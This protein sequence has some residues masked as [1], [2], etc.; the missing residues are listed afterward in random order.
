M[1]DQP[2]QT[3]DC[4]GYDVTIWET[5]GDKVFTY[6]QIG[7]VLNEIAN[8]FAFQLEE[9]EET[10]R[11]HFQIRL[12]AIKKTRWRPLTKLFINALDVKGIKGHI[13]IK[14]TSAGIHSKR[15]F[16]YVLK[17]DTRIA[18]PW[19][20]QDFTEDEAKWIPTKY[21]N[22]NPENLKPFQKSLIEM[23]KIYDD[24]V[25]DVI[26][27]PLG[28]VGK[29]FIK[30]FMY[31]FEDSHILPSIDDYKL[32]N[33]DANNAVANR[34]KKYGPMSDK[35]NIKSFVLDLPRGMEI[36]AMRS[37]CQAIETIKDG[38]LVDWRNKSNT[39]LIDE[40]RIFIFTNDIVHLNYTK[41]RLKTWRIDNKA[42]LIPYTFPKEDKP[43]NLVDYTVQPLFKEKEKEKKIIKLV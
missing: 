24:R 36:G 8:K 35:R 3:V 10:K 14:P 26:Y 40:P 19:T 30:K 31:L 20:E 25:I 34:I 21:R 39:L 23:S 42:C 41:D 33:Q 17:A 5:M 32:V 22:F 29:G 4:K 43:Y 12:N 6:S 11:R 18:G 7:K 28:N 9:G 38:W 16:N 1:T 15:N 27:D 13:H 2:E 37:L